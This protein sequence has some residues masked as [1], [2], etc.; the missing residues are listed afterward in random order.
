MIDVVGGAEPTLLTSDAGAVSSMTWS[1]DGTVIT[2][3]SGASRVGRLYVIGADGSGLRLLAETSSRLSSGF[4]VMWS[5]DGTR[6]G[7][8]VIA[9]PT[10]SSELEIWTASPHG[11]NAIRVHAGCCVTDFGVGPFW[12]PDGTRLAFQDVA[13][14]WRVTPADGTGG[15]ELIDH[16][17]AISWQ[18]G[19]LG[20]EPPYSPDAIPYP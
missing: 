5:P 7:Y 2:L 4:G 10:D 16:F 9:G 1:P 19:E 15:L 14:T 17:V 3:D 11:S 8:H 6:I 20:V 18:G 12:S 13:G